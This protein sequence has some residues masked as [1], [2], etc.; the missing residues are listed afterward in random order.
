MHR[1]PARR[2]ALLLVSSLAGAT[3]V[4][5]QEEPERGGPTVIM[6]VPYAGISIPTRTLLPDDDGGSGWEAR[7]GW[8]LGGRL[9][10]PIRPRLEAVADLGYARSEIRGIGSGNANQTG[11][12]NFLAVTAR[13]TYQVTPMRSRVMVAVNA[14]GGWIRHWIASPQPDASNWPTAV[15][16]VQAGVPFMRGIRLVL[17]A[18]ALIYNAKFGGPDPVTTAQQDFRFSVGVLGGR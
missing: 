2:L 14:G 6:I 9:Q 15:A 1:T 18:E 7:T 10:V 8:L 12:A 5:A 4:T 16:G 17:G 3:A 11:K 13:A